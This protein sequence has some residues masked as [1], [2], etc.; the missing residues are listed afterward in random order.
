[1]SSPIFIDP[2]KPYYI[3]YNPN[4]TISANSK[5]IVVS[6]GDVNRHKFIKYESTVVQQIQLYGTVKYQKIEQSEFNP[7][8]EK[9]FAEAM[10]GLNFYTTEEIK[11]M[12]VEKKRHVIVLYTRVQ[13]MLNIWKQEIIGKQ[14]DHFFATLFPNSPFTKFLL[15]NEFYDKNLECPLSLRDLGVTSEKLIAEKL[16]E[17]RLLPYNFFKLT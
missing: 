4:K 13:K 16:V 5:G 1:M 14:V 6:F 3:M 8:Q 17:S 10:Y 15:A 7:T 2:F 12:P 9:L 11:T